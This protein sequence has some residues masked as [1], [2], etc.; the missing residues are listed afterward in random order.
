M[1]TVLKSASAKWFAIIQSNVQLPQKSALNGKETKLLLLDWIY[2]VLRV[3]TE[4]LMVFG[5]EKTKL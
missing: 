4:F 5:Y 2:L 1:K 3:S